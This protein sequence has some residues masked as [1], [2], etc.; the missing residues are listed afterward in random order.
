MI[1][2]SGIEKGRVFGILQPSRSLGDAELKLKTPVRPNRRALRESRKLGQ[3][4]ETW[5]DKPNTAISSDPE[6][7]C[8]T[9]DESMHALILGSDGLYE[10]L[11]PKEI[12]R[13]VHENVEHDN[14][15]DNV[16]YQLC[17]LSRARGVRDDI[18]CI[19]VYL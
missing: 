16:A 18:S 5:I 9:R 14:N 8:V 7:R 15:K 6:L 17:S 3:P 4:L 12:A 19:V 10:A 2:W 11:S 13:I 1:N